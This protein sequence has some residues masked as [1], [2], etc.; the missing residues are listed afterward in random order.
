MH[1][2]N[3]A[4]G[5]GG[6]GWFR[7]QTGHQGL[8]E[9]LVRHLR[10]HRVQGVEMAVCSSVNRMVLLL[11]SFCSVFSLAFCCPTGGML[12]AKSLAA[13]RMAQHC[14][15]LCRAVRGLHHCALQSVY[16]KTA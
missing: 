4:L 10:G 15:L 8:V 9:P 2:H 5:G 1:H 16:G 6:R 13:R 3:A 14:A 12:A 11:V 7:R